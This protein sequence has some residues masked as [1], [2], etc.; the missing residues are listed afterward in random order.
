MSVLPFGEEVLMG[1]LGV[2]KSQS[3]KHTSQLHKQ[4]ML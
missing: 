1:T 3:E 4:D 2:P